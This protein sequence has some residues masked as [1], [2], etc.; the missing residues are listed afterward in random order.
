MR[1]K[2]VDLSKILMVLMIC[3][4]LKWSLYPVSLLF[5]SEL[6]GEKLPVANIRWAGS[7]ANG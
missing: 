4:H 7:G 2:L 5:K 1:I 3:N 6:D